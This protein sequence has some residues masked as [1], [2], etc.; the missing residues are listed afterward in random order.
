ME[1]KPKKGGSFLHIF[2]NIFLQSFLKTIVLKAFTP[3]SPYGEKLGNAYR[4]RFLSS[5]TI[6]GLWGFGIGLYNK[7]CLQIRSNILPLL[8]QIDLKLKICNNST[9]STFILRNLKFIWSQKVKNSKWLKLLHPLFDSI[10]NNF[11]VPDIEIFK[12]FFNFFFLQS[13][14]G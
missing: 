5:L 13:G 12:P 9:G 8:N 4:Q 1:N 11:N 6:L 2:P 14:D 10:R 3:S 7:N